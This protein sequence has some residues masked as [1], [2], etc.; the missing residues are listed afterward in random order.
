MSRKPGD[1]IEKD[2]SATEPQGFD[3]TDYL[4]ELGAGV[5]IATSTWAVDSGPDA[6]L[7][8]ANDS[9][10]VGSLKTQV[11]LVAG[12]LGGRYTVRNRIVTNSTPPVT[13]DRSFDVFMVQR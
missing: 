12:T 6:I 5:L 1:L 7:T 2:P 10:V 13:D 8:L 4:L 9:I 3:W 11:Y